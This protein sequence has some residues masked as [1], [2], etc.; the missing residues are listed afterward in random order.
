[1]CSSTLSSCAARVRRTLTTLRVQE[2]SGSR[3]RRSE[4][5][6]DRRRTNAAGHRSTVVIDA[7]LARCSRARKKLARVKQ[8]REALEAS[9]A[10]HISGLNSVAVLTRPSAV[11]ETLPSDPAPSECS[12]WN[13][14]RRGGCSLHRARRS[15][16][17]RWWR[18]LCRRARRWR[19]PSPSSRCA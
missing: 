13:W 8:A 10:D 16:G 7:G 17:H 19:A 18:H 15:P 9:R 2:P 5:R 1:M 11:T 4:S 14:H 12:R 3:D 6:Q